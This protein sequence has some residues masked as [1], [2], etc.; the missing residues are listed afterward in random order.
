[1]ERTRT[2]IS[3]DPQVYEVFQRMADAAGISVSRCMG[4]WLADTIDAA[5][6]ATDKLLQIRRSPERAMQEAMQA[7]AGETVRVMENPPV[8][9]R[10]P[11]TRVSAAVSADRAPSSNTGLKSP[12]KGRK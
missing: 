3:L 5:Q 12:R 6:L 7:I 1:M 2:T 8:R 9:W 4:D 11:G 10:A